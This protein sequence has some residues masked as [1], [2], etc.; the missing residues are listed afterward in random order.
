MSMLPPAEIGAPLSAVDTPA[1]LID[2]DAFERNL[3]AMADAGKTLGVRLR[4][5]AKTHKSPIIAAKQ[6]ARGAIGV[7]CQKVSEAEILVAGGVSDVLVSNEVVGAYKLERL[8]RLAR[9]ARISVCV[10]HPD[11]VAQLAAA[12]ERAGS[13]IEIL[14]EIDV[15]AKRCGI[16]PG[17]SAVELARR[18]ASARG[19]SFGGLQAYHGSAQH[20]RTPAERRAAIDAAFKAVADDDAAIGRCRL[21]LPYDR[22]RR[23]RHVRAGRRKRRVE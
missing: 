18:I 14:I 9:H 3:D 2:L 5:H 20:L 6:I 21:C 22:R 13:Q 4:P 17:P 11:I 7:C 10:D 1:L 8:A 23:H 12:A 15:G 19:L 16:A